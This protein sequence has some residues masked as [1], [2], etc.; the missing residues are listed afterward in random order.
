MKFAFSK[1]QI[2][3]G[4]NQVPIIIPIDFINIDKEIYHVSASYTYTV[5]GGGAP[6]PML[7]GQNIVGNVMI[8]QDISVSNFDAVEFDYCDLT[9][10]P[11]EIFGAGAKVL[12]SQ[13]VSRT[14]TFG[15]Y[16]GEMALGNGKCAIVLTPGYVETVDSKGGPSETI[17]FLSVSGNDLRK[18]ADY[19]LKTPSAA[20][21]R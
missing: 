10:L 13:I 2:V 8:V 14:A 12:F 7:E 21:R 9:I 19:D 15:F 3:G 1:K 5:P 4:A 17:G 18:G 6:G 11:E 16:A 20:A